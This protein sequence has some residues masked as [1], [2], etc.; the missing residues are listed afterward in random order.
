[1]TE[2]CGLPVCD[3]QAYDLSRSRD[4]HDDLEGRVNDRPLVG[5]EMF[6][7]LLNHTHIVSSSCKI[8][9]CSR[10]ISSIIPRLHFTILIAVL[11]R[12]QFIDENSVYLEWP[13]GLAPRG[14]LKDMNREH[15]SVSYPTG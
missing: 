6:T 5:S 10:C 14:V 13:D 1:M 3:A 15:S 4:Q 8:L 11:T 12:L 2:F 9:S 7:A